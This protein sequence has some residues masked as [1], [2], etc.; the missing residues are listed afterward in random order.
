M[1][2]TENKEIVKGFMA[3]IE[4]VRDT[5]DA[6]IMDKFLAPDVLLDITGFPPN[7][8]GR[9]AFTQGMFMFINAFP[10]LKITEL[11]PMIAQGDKVAVRVSWTGTHT[12]D[13]MGIPATGK[14]VNI[15]DMHIERIANGKIVERIAVT[16][17]MGIMQQI[18]MVPA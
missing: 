17:S 3:A 7:S 5:G 15:V 2:T 14:R 10:D 18:G 12:G 6:S 16:D 11:S 9:E 1:S 8:R 4:K 13:L